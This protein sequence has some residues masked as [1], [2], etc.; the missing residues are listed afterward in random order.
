M[1]KTRKTVEVTLRSEEKIGGVKYSFNASRRSGGEEQ[2][3][4]FGYVGEG[5]SN[6][7]SLGGTEEDIRLFL[8]AVEVLM[9]AIKEEYEREMKEK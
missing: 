1:N 5:M 9:I 8:E 2:Y 3:Y 6:V 4:I 7:L